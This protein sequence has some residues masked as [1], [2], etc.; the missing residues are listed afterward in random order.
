MTTFALSTSVA[1]VILL[2]GFVIL[3]IYRFGLLGSYSAYA[4][5][6]DAAYPIHNANLW[7]IITIA[8]ALLMMPAMIE[9]GESNPLQLFGFFTP[10]Y[11]IIVGLTPKW[12][13]S[14]K[15]N[16]VHTMFAFI[17]AVVAASWIV[18]VAKIWWSLAIAFAAVLLLS[19]A[20]RTLRH[21]LVFWA[22]VVMFA[23]TY[24]VVLFN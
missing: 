13:S 10:I 11:L 3:S 16:L 23:A 17:C 18:F 5:R 14:S 6:W 1:S 22:E 15:Q 24:S 2:A 7:S 20:T 8:S 12:E 9:L 19:L 21:S 4:K